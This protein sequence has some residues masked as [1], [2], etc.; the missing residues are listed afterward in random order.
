MPSPDATPVFYPND[1]EYYE[2]GYKY[3]IIISK[4]I[5]I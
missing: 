2:T 1:K 4:D 3:R 5:G